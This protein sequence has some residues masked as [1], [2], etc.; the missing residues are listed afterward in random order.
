MT[1]AGASLDDISDF[2]VG[3][4]IF[5]VTLTLAVLAVLPVV[6]EAL[7]WLG[8]L[9]RATGLVSPWPWTSGDDGPGPFG[10]EVQ[11]T[12]RLLFIAGIYFWA[13]REPGAVGPL[14]VFLLG[15]VSDLLAGGIVGLTALTGLIVFGGVIAVAQRLAPRARLPGV[16]VAAVFPLIAG[17][18]AVVWWA[19]YGGFGRAEV[20]TVG[21]ERW[22]KAALAAGLLFPFLGGFLRLLSALVGRVR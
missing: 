19:A 14:M 17:A 4:R 16:M 12:A 20:P 11:V 22:L 21:L 15:L 8:A 2:G 1:S 7:S 3:L 13:L 5:V 10:A 6:P 18:V 9:M